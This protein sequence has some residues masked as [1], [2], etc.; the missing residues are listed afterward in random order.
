MTWQHGYHTDSPYTCGYY[1]ELAPAWL[2]FASLLQGQLPPRSRQGE[3][4]S[5]LELGSGMGLGLCLLAATHPEGK[6]TGID[7]KP[8]H[9]LH[10]RRLARDLA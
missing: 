7:F 8:D 10:S 2:D 1:R 3:P 6:F 4:F 9:I 5:Y